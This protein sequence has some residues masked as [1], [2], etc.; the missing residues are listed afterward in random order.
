MRQRI[1]LFYFISRPA[2]LPDYKSGR[3]EDL[4]F[5]I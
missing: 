1:H 2:G 3:T 4:K 5:K